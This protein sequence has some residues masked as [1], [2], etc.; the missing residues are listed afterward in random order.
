MGHRETS[1][2]GK[3][4]SWEILVD[5]LEQQKSNTSG[6]TAVIEQRADLI[7]DALNQIIEVAS[8]GGC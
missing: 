1:H 8:L 4:H 7:S 2:Y 6:L 5:G 3:Y